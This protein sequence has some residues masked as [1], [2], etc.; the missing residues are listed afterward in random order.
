MPR[1]FCRG[2]SGSLGSFERRF[3]LGTEYAYHD[4]LSIKIRGLIR[5]GYALLGGN[6][7]YMLMW[8]ENLKGIG[9]SQRQIANALQRKN[10]KAG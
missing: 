6:P 4:P 10:R 5:T 2:W 3:T 1:M 7:R 8:Y 9:Y